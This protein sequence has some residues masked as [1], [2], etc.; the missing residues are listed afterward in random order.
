M[1]V[2]SIHHWYK[3]RTHMCYRR[4][5]LHTSMCYRCPV[6]HWYKL[7]TSVCYRRPYVLYTTNVR[8]SCTLLIQATSVCNTCHGHVLC[9]LLIQATQVCVSVCRVNHYIVI[10]A[11]HI[12]VSPCTR[13]MQATHVRAIFLIDFFNT[14][15]ICAI[16]M[17]PSQYVCV[18]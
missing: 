13:L 8:V 10:Q 2:C 6:R 5:V 1:S 17:H 14:F 16:C 3:L 4:R 15:V 9:T 12:Q 7:R 11:T 18:I